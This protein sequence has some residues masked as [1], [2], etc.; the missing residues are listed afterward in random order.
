MSLSIP[1]SSD[2]YSAGWE[3]AALA[4]QRGQNQNDPS[5]PVG[6][7][8]WQL[9]HWKVMQIVLNGNHAMRDTAARDYIPQL[10]NEDDA[11]YQRRLKAGLFSPYTSRLIDAAVGLIL[12]KP[13]TLEGGNEEFWKDWWKNVDRQGTDGDE[14]ARRVLRN[15]IGYGH[16]SMLVD[17][18]KA[19]GIRTLADER[20]AKLAPYLN[21][22]EPWEVL[23]WRQDARE[24]Q[25]KLQQVRIRETVSI[26]EGDFGEKLVEQIRVLEPGNYRLFQREGRSEWAEVESGT[27][28]LQDIPLV[29]TYAQK[30][31]MQ[32]STPPLLDIAYIN[33]AHYRLQSQHLNALQTAG[34][35]ILVLHGWDDQSPKLQIDVSKALAMPPEGRVEYVEPANAAFDAY[36]TELSE[37][38]NQMSNLGISV[39]TQQKF[40]A[41]A[42]KKAQLDRIDTNSM[43]A[44][45]SQDLEQ[46]L[47][48]VVD[49]AAEYA[50]Q[51]APTVGIPRDFDATRLEGND[52]TSVIALFTS[53]IIDQ[54]TAL[55]VLHR[56]EWLDDSVD[57]DEIMSQTEVNELHEIDMQ[58]KRTEAMAEIGEGTPANDDELNG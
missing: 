38:E 27:T 55:Q 49:L 20:A 26:P 43:L 12:R 56:G 28:S 51:E 44:N 39:L 48:E 50:G 29:T 6:A 14:F 21:V 4:N 37:L 15:S 35:P 22:V 17:Y 23:G 3:G 42:A 25:G 2:P 1:V 54:Q 46:A 30:E 52:V 36:Q 41:E 58:V 19:E 34:F 33:L 13:V 7:Y 9:S 45:I 47:Q 57:I 8:Y 18:P 24:N 53:G 40:A 11:C 10:P 16:C 32:V 5:L 31:A